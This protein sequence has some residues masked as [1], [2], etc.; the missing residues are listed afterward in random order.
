M[1]C[2]NAEGRK[3]QF[4]Q[5]KAVSLHNKVLSSFC[6]QNCSL[7]QTPTEYCRTVVKVGGLE[8]SFLCTLL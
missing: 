5:H 7:K 4:D 1:C 6:V 2:K 3:R 8:K